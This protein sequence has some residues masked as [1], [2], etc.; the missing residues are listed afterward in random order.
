MLLEAVHGQSMTWKT[1]YKRKSSA[2]F[3]QN[4]GIINYKHLLLDIDNW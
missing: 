4:I 1:I 3:K 2:Y